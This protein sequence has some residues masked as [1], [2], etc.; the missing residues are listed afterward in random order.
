MR[1]GTES[2][3]GKLGTIVGLLLLIGVIWAGINIGKVFYANYSFSDKM[4]EIA[5]TPRY[6]MNDD[7]VMDLLMKEASEQ[8]LHTY[9]SREGCVIDTQAT[10]RKIRCEYDREVEI[11]PG[12]K[13]VFHFKNQADQPL[14]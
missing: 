14:I 9:L 3:E 13:H 10:F 1:H 8:R 2:G 7:R 6:R 4:I 5:R 11:L 12:W